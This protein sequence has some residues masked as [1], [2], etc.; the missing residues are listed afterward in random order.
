MNTRVFSTLLLT[1]PSESEVAGGWLLLC[2]LHVPKISI[3]V[4]KVGCSEGSMFKASDENDCKTRK[5]S[6]TSFLESDLGVQTECS[7]WFHI[8][9]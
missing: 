5:T 6:I 9:W 8:I 7:W 2:E 3:Q 4:F 1:K